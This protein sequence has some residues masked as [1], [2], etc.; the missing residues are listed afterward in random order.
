MEVSGQLH[1]PAALR[2]GKSPRHQFQSRLSGPQSRSGRGAD[3]KNKSFHTP[4]RNRTPVSARDLLSI[5]T[6][7]FRP[8]L[9]TEL[10]EIYVQT[11]INMV[12]GDVF[13]SFRIESITK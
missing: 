2:P 3:K 5:S 6:E 9:N 11:I 8:L 1:A 12:Y 4:A 10:R 13:K 7:I